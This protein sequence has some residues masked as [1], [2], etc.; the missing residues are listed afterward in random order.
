MKDGE[1]NFLEYLAGEEQNLLVSIVNFRSDFDA[2]YNLD[3]ICQEPLRY[4]EVSKE[5]DIVPSLFLFVHFHLYFSVS[6]LLR[7][8][9]SESLA[10]TRKAID[11]SLS[12]YRII[13]DPKMAD[14]YK[15]RDNSFL[16]IKSHIQR[17][18]KTDSSKYP[19]AEGLL[20]LHDMCSEYGS[21]ADVSSFVHRVEVRDLPD[22][23]KQNL[24]FHYFQF[25]KDPNEY[26]VYLIDTIF[27]F[28]GMLQIFRDFF[29]PRVKKANPGW[30]EKVDALGKL[31]NKR[32]TELYGTIKRTRPDAMAEIEAQQPR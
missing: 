29:E 4:L 24:M 20:E 27:A 11:A 22:K 10:S 7:S 26:A 16:H 19:F 6:C 2:F 31:L 28:Y 15:T 5:E 17:E 18:R 8:H 12:A 30:G 32:R 23:N 13:L 3:N 1:L 25:P 9:F 21:H 14:L